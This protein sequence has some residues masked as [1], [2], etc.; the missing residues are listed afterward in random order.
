[1]ARLVSLTLPADRLEEV[2]GVL[3]AS[4]AIGCYDIMEARRVVRGD[5]RLAGSKMV[6][7]QFKLRTSYLSDTLKQLKM[8]GMGDHGGSVRCCGMPTASRRP[9]AVRVWRAG[10]TGAAVLHDG[11]ASSGH[12]E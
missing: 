8:V 4:P 10:C 12:G 7:V 2:E 6:Q 5:T 9:L 3:G 1:M 11:A